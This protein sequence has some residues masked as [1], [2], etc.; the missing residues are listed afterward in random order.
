MPRICDPQ[1]SY[2]S[3]PIETKI[4]LHH[5]FCTRSFWAWSILVTGPC[6]VNSFAYVVF[7]GMRERERVA[8]VERHICCVCSL[9]SISSAWFVF[10]CCLLPC[11]THGQ[12]VAWTCSFHLLFCLN[13]QALSCTERDV[14]ARVPSKPSDVERLRRI[15]GRWTAVYII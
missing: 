13:H 15:V 10:Y 8:R 2:S 7:S 1:G 5:S 14:A 9:T 3:N 11:A 12:M 4:T 6:D